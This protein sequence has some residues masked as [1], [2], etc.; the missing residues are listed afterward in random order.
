MSSTKNEQA[1]SVTILKDLSEREQAL[2][3]EIEVLEEQVEE[4]RVAKRAIERIY[5]TSDAS[6]VEPGSLAGMTIAQASEQVLRLAGHEV[7]SA[8]LWKM[9]Q[10]GGITT[11]STN[12]TNNLNANLGAR[13]MFE[14]GSGG[15]WLLSDEIRLTNDL[16]ENRS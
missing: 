15:G 3:S 13:D 12:P 4:I 10:R 14:R 8:E 2:E 7:Q 11:S 16:W 6:S 1:G 5:G 9:L